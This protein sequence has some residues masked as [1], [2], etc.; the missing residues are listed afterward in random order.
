M[1]RAS[2]QRGVTILELLIV[3]AIIAVLATIVMLS[4]SSFRQN[5]ALQTNAENIVSMLSKARSNTIASKD[6]YQYGVHFATG[7]VTI[8]RGASYVSGD[9]NNEVYTLDAALE[10]SA[11][12]LTGGG[13]DV[14]F[15]KFT[16]KTAQYGTTTIRVIADSTKTTVIS[17]EQTGSIGFQ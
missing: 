17:I 16:G 4:F 3:V 7:D 15:Q 5:S 12:S 10:I 2:F 1:Q 9:G 13:S 8:F 14:V 6:G 11:I